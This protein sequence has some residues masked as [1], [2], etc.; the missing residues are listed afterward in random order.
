MVYIYIG[1]TM[2]PYTLW[3]WKWS[4]PPVRY[5]AKGH[6]QF[7][8]PCSLPQ[9]R[10][11]GPAGTLKRKLRHLSVDE[12]KCACCDHGH[13]IDGHKVM[14]DRQIVK[15]CVCIWFGSEEAFEELI[16]SEVLDALS[17]G[18]QNG[19]FT[20]SWSLCVTRRIPESRSPQPGRWSSTIKSSRAREEDH[21]V[22]HFFPRSWPYLLAISCL[23]V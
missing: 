23:C 17:A 2:I 9:R 7:S 21:Q 19:V 5:S 13:V 15:E 14:C 16:R 22:F 8:G 10:A 3:N 4:S 12:T 20:R 11:W 1:Q 6:F 18:L